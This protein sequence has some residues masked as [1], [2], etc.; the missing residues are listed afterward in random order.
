MLFH[1]WPF[2]LFLLVVVPVFYALRHTRLWI[3]WLMA[4]SYFFYGWWNPYYLALVFYSTTLDYFLV[5]LMD[6]CPRGGARVDVIGRLT[7]LRFDDR[8]LQ[9]AFLISATA[10]AALADEF[11]VG[12]KAHRLSRSGVGG[13]TAQGKV[14]LF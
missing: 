2:L 4:A 9:A 13:A 8:V 14:V 1:T 3:P 7:R 12:G 10:T 6:H 11:G 5:A